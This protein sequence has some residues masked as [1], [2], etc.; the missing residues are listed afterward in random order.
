MGSK[1]RPIDARVVAR[2]AAGQGVGGT[3]RTGST[4][5]LAGL[6]IVAVAG[7]PPASAG[8]VRLA[9]AGSGLERLPGRPPH[10]ASVRDRERAR[11]ECIRI[12]ERRG[13]TVEGT[14][15]ARAMDE[16]QVRLRMDLRRRDERWLADCTFD[17]RQRR[18]EFEARRVERD[19]RRDR[20]HETDRRRGGPVSD[21]RV[22][23][24]CIAEVTK[25][26]R[27]QLVAAGRVER[28][29]SGASV[30]PMTIRVEGTERRVRCFFDHATGAVTIR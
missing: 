12:A 1:S 4:I 8:A 11:R 20:D 13:F 6:V 26:A 25:D 7:T 24:A 17:T 5:L 27:T 30:M 14:T 28:R 2:L 19:R 9:Q 22:R 10:A 29:S 3:V 21:G 15:P 16:H 18:A 23:D